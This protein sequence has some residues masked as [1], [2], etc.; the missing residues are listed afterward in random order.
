VTTLHR[1]LL[2]TACGL[3]LTRA[4]AQSFSAQVTADNHYQLYIGD[5]AGTQLTLVGQNESGST[6]NPGAYN[7]SEPE[8]WNFQLSLGQRIYVVAWD[9][10]G[11]GGWLGQFGSV[12]G[13]L[14]SNPSSW[15]YTTS[16][17]AN[18][19]DSQPNLLPTL[20]LD[21]ASASSGGSW[22]ANPSSSGANGTGPWGTIPGIGSSAEW[23]NVPSNFG[24]V[25]VFRSEFV[26]VPEA[27]GVSAAVAAVVVGAAVAFRHHRRRG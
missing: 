2:V 21:I 18:P 6:G 15:R 24:P 26:G 10:G 23:L 13:T 12:A 1:C 4:A 27:P 16:S 9:A 3:A 17:A 25:T 7:W 19:G 20:L 14:F 11:Q 8:S 22:M 5:T